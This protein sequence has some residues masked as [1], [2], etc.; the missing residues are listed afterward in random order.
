MSDDP[1]VLEVT[2][3]THTVT[4]I[5]PIGCHDVQT[6]QGGLVHF[7]EGTGLFTSLIEGAGEGNPPTSGAILAYFDGENGAPGR[8]IVVQLT[9]T[10]MRE[11]AASLLLKADEL[12]PMRPN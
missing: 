4:G 10:A 7:C 2:G 8:G 3:E 9:A 11:I 5:T 1:I 6:P 12:E